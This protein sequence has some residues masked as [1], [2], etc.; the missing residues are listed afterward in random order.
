MPTSVERLT[1]IVPAAQMPPPWLLAV[2]FCN[3]ECQTL[4]LVP[5]SAHSAP[6]WA[7]ELNVMC[8]WS[9]FTVPAS[10]LIAPPQSPGAL[11]PVS[12]MFFSV[13][14]PRACSKMRLPGFAT[15]VTLPLPSISNGPLVR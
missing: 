14:V 2:F 8:T 13:N 11:P 1:S 3:S 7:A 10:T 9:R 5:A 6:P 12:V 15:R 4:T